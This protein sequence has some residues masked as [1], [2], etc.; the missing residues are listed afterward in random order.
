MQSRLSC[1]LNIIYLN[2]SWIV[3]IPSNMYVQ[4]FIN[5]LQTQFAHDIQGIYLFELKTNRILDPKITFDQNNIQS[6]DY[7]Y[8]I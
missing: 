7:L 8:F 5:L 2:M 1:Y 6:G 4:D 3:E